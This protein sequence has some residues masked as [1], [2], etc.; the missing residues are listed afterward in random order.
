MNEKA[1]FKVALKRHLNTHSFNS[2]DEYLLSRKQL[3]HGR[4]AY[5][6]MLCRVA[7]VR[8]DVSEEL[9]NRIKSF[10]YKKI[11]QFLLKS[12]YG[13]YGRQNDVYCSIFRYATGVRQGLAQWPSLQNQEETTESNILATAI[14]LNGKI[15]P[16]QNK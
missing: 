8:A 16:N 15:L 5:C 4:M 12:I 1:Q 14:L 13:I 6:G 3:M 2:A 11:F 10:L 7:L 9:M